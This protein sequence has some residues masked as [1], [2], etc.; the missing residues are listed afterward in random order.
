M[1]ARPTR[2][3]E[4]V[5]VPFDYPRDESLHESRVFGELR[6]HIR[7]LVMREYAAQARQAAGTTHQ[8]ETR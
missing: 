7:E 2:V 1:S 8:E 4:I 5:D 6:S 3:R